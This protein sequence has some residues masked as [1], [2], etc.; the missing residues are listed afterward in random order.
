MTCSFGKT[1]PPVITLVCLW[2]LAALSGCGVADYGKLKSNPEVAKDFQAYKPLPAHKYYYRG[3][4]S[5]PSVVAGISENYV[6]SSKLWVEIDPGSEQFRTI[7]DRV[8]LQDVGGRINPWGFT[9]LDNAG[10]YVGVWYS[11][12]GA[13]AVEIDATG[14]IVNLSPQTTVTKGDQR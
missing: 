14:R 9:I 11:A 12:S 6:L 13:A 2:I 8:S 10:N 7:V 4:Q 1:G 5:R 3:T